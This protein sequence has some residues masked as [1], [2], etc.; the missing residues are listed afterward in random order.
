VVVVAVD[1]LRGDML[2]RYD[3]LFQGGIRRLLDRGTSFPRTTFGHAET[4]TGPGHATIS[5]GMHPAGHGIAGNGWSELR[6]GAWTDVYAVE[7]PEHPLLADPE[8]PGRSP[9]NLRRDGLA[10][11]IR[12][13]HPDARVVSVSRKDRA[14]IPLA[15]RGP[16]H[17]YW[18]ALDQGVEGFT[19]STFYRDSLPDWV[20]AA[21][22]ELAPV[23]WSDTVWVSDAPQEA[24]ERA[25]P[26]PFPTEGDGVHTTLP[27]RAWQEAGLPERAEWGDW[28]EGTPSTDAAVVHL[29]SRAVREL[30]LGRRDAVDY[31]ALGLSSTDG[32]GHGY[33]PWSQEQLD[34][35]LR[36]DRGLGAL[37]DS[38]DAAVGSDGWVLALTGDHGVLEMVEWRQEQGL[39][40]HRLSRE[41]RTGMEARARTHAGDPD[42]LASALEE[43]DVVADAMTLE[44]LRDGGTP[45]DT[46]VPLFRRSHVEGRVTGPFPG[47]GVVVRLREGV[48]GGSLGTGHGSPY[49]YDRWVPFLLYG[50]GVPAAVRDEAAG[51]VDVA[52]TLARLVGVPAPSELDGVARTP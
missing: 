45:A 22:A 47:A 31:L 30:A 28:L 39:P 52:P 29:A 7:D 46:F 26:D 16:G 20:H 23:L 43:L 32:V 38:L 33:G 5:T 2:T 34:N 13:A 14:A 21:N 50:P 17:V 11:W 25:R 3:D 12:A 1:Q 27:H 35:L 6:D 9:A 40:G 41:E 42:A 19:T 51:V 49:H 36:L 18:L 8:L 24:R 15:G 37:M 10:D 48:Y 44:E 4:A